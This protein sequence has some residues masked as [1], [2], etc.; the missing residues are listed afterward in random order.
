MGKVTAGLPLLGR[1]KRCN[2][3]SGLNGNATM[4]MPTPSSEWARPANHLRALEW[5]IIH[6]ISRLLGAAG[7]TKSVIVTF[8]LV[9]ASFQE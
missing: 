8:F 1:T 7:L 3:P 2:L 9:L 4:G 5:S 6:L